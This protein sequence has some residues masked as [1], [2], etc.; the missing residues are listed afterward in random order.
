MDGPWTG[1]VG[2]YLGTSEVALNLSTP[3]GE[4]REYAV[5]LLAEYLDEVLNPGVASIKRTWEL[6]DAGQTAMQAIGNVVNEQSGK[7]FAT[8]F[9]HY[10]ETAYTMT[11]SDNDLQSWI[12]ALVDY[13]KPVRH[14]DVSFLYYTGP[15]SDCGTNPQCSFGA[16]RPKR[17]VVLVSPWA[18]PDQEIPFEPDV[19]YRYRLRVTATEIDHKDWR[20]GDPEPTTWTATSTAPSGQSLTMTNAYLWLFNANYGVR[21]SIDWIKMRG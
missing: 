15:Y 11:F 12:D 5:N 20:D 19:W 10:A 1:D 3:T 6:I 8:E 21:W 2:A 18:A 16:D 17:H 7:D 14:P 4:Q 9:Q 13:S